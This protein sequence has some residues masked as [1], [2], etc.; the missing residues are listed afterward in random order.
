MILVFFDGLG[1]GDW[2]SPFI[3]LGF[4]AVSLTRKKKVFARQ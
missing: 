1:F 2:R 4:S 3:H